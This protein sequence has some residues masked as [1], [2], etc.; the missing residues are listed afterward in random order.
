[1]NIYV[2]V[3]VCITPTLFKS[4]QKCE[5]FVPILLYFVYFKNPLQ[6]A[7]VNTDFSCC[8]HFSNLPLINELEK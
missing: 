4:S 7:Y 5:K 6:Y 1:M 8:S 3:S 2:C